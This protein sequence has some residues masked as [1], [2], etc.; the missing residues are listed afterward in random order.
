[1]L[2]SAHSASESRPGRISLDYGT[3]G[4]ALPDKS[5]SDRKFCSDRCRRVANRESGRVASVRRL[6]SGMMSVIIHMH[7][8]GLRPG[9]QVKVGK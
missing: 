3:C 2:E 5:R 9:D 4:G 7:D 8:A 1:M 6:E